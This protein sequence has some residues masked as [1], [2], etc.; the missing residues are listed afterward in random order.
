MELERTVNEQE[1]ANRSLQEQVHRSQRID[2][3]NQ[4][5]MET[6]QLEMASFKKALND[7]KV[8]L[9]MKEK[10]GGKVLGKGEKLLS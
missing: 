2:A 9:K 4:D 10:F 7:A 8:M 5:H 6:K 1:D 3:Q